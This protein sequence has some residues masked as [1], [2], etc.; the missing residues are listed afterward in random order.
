M[1]RPAEVEAGYRA[2][3]PE[4]AQLQ[5]AMLGAALAAFALLYCTQ[6]LL[7][8]IGGDLAVSPA[9][10][11][12][13]VSA[14]TGAL[15][16]AILPLSSLAEAF[17]RIRLMRIGLV[18]A[19]ALVLVSA[20]APN[21]WILV[22]LRALIGVALAAVV[23]VAMGHVGD[24]VHPSSLG[25]AMGV[26]VAGNSLGGV[27]GRLV[28]AAAGDGTSW[29]YGVLAVGVL[30]VAAT[31]AFSYQI[32]EA[33]RFHR[34]PLSWPV[35]RRTVL[36]HLADS[37]IVRLCLIAFLLMGGFVATYNYLAYRLL[38][39]PFELSQ[40]VIGLVFLAYLAGTASSTLAGRLA[41]RWGARTTLLA[42]TLVMAGGLTLTLPEQV[43]L[44]VAGLLIFTAGFFG[45]HAVASGWV[46]RRATTARAQAS[47]LYLLAYYAGSSVLGTATGLAFSH[48][49]WPLMVLSVTTYLTLA[50]VLAASMTER[51]PGI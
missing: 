28:A 12:L 1:P 6:P 36:G 49:G 43:G 40:G 30:A 42:S 38:R 50:L 22:A 15:A 37:G 27:G 31:V 5:R 4:F 39:A 2:G 46:A 26:Y 17:G 47:A 21:F 33:G 20:A 44:I 23:A 8:A 18:S 48:G 41:D 11:S 32:P 13:T 19:C 25:S 34:V 10:A 45:A 29:R 9:A 51:L 14:G 3:T 16:I 35:L 24:E 7:P